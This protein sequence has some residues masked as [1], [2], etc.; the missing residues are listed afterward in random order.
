[1]LQIVGG[2]AA[3]AAHLTGDDDAVRRDQGL[4]GHAGIGIGR[5]ERIEHGIRDTVRHLVGM[6]LGNGFRR[7]EI[8]VTHDVGVVLG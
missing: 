4:A 1:V 6:A 3:G 7:E 5:Q 8:V 2:D